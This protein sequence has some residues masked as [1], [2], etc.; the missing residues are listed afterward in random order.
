MR[1]R[2]AAEVDKRSGR[3]NHV[4]EL[5]GGPLDQHTMLRIVASPLAGRAL[6]VVHEAKE[7]ARGRHGGDATRAAKTPQPRQIDGSACGSDAT[8]CSGLH[9]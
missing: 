8:E 7:P 4:R 6:A 5:T 2:T 3:C 1:A 9:L